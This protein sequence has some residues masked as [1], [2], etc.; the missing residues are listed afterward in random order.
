VSNSPI[1]DP[2]AQAVA[3]DIAA[4][5]R[6]RAAA[7]RKRANDLI[8]VIDCRGS[9]ITVVPSEARVLKARRAQAAERS[10]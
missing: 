3:A 4:A 2:F 8:A 7:Q 6:K 9:P 5:L 1:A 10:Q